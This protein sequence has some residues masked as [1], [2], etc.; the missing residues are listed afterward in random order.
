ML[1]RLCLPRV[2]VSKNANF[3]QFLLKMK[4]SEYINKSADSWLVAD[5][6]VQC[7]YILRETC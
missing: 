2:C 3:T 6:K 7:F 4:C 5:R 1:S